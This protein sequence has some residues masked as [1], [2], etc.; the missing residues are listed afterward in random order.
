MAKYW[1]YNGSVLSITMMSQWW[2]RWRLKSLVSRLFTQPFIQ[3]ADQRKH[4]SSASLAF[5]RGIH[6][7]PVN[8]PHKGPVTRKMF[9]FD[10]VILGVPHG[11]FS[12]NFH[13]D[14]TVVNGRYAPKMTELIPNSKEIV[15]WNIRV[16]LANTKT[17]QSTTK[18]WHCVY[19]HESTSMDKQSYVQSRVRSNHLS[20]S[21]L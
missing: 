17:N 21:K 16:T 1:E 7:W 12:G 19:L 20:I 10:D 8:S 15:F 9:P 2:A 14:L 13:T 4:Q 5:V 11:L 6:R 3:G 18:Y